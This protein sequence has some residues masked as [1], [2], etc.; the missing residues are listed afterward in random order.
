MR[1]AVQCLDFYRVGSNVL[2]VKKWNKDKMFKPVWI[3]PERKFHLESRIRYGIAVFLRCYR[4]QAYSKMVAL[5]KILCYVT[6]YIIHAVA[7]NIYVLHHGLLCWHSEKYRPTCR[8][9]LSWHQKVQV[10]KNIRVIAL[11]HLDSCSHGLRKH[12]QYKVKIYL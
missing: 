12:K 11:S 3:S 5:L 1:F 10:G 9:V 8:L 2:H 4:L 7:Q 6:L